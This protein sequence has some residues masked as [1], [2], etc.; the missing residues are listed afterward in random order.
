MIQQEQIKWRLQKSLR[1]YPDAEITDRKPLG[2][3]DTFLA[4][5]KRGRK[6]SVFTLSR[7]E[8][9]QAADKLDDLIAARLTTTLLR[10]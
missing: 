7:A 6:T 9:V 5:I 2:A 1:R 8:I 10:N 3:P 4:E